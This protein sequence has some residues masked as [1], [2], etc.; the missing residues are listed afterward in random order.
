M[1]KYLKEHEKSPKIGDP[2]AQFNLSYAIFYCFKGS[3]M[4]EI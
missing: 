2:V 1:L 4:H 3:E